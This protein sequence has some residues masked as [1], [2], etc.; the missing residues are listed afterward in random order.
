MSNIS[1]I[2]L[3]PGMD[4]AMMVSVINTNFEQIRSENRTKV[5]KD[6][7]GVNRILIG[8]GPK[9]NYVI[10]ISVPGVDVLTALEK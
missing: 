2:V 10:A 3:T 4:M 1:P 8:R 6:E 9:G 7:N 5:I